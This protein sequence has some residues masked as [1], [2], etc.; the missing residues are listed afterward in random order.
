[1]LGC[2]IALLIVLGF[3]FLVG[4]C[5]NICSTCDESPDRC[6]T[7]KHY[8]PIVKPSHYEPRDYDISSETLKKFNEFTDEEKEKV[9]AYWNKKM[10]PQLSKL[11]ERINNL[12]DEEFRELDKQVKSRGY[13][14]GRD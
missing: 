13:E 8:K 9:V 7:C 3:L 12:T 5:S 10:S 14:D 1:M 2:G 4:A 11:A 6:K